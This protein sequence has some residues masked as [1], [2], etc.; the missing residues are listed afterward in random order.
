MLANGYMV[1][2]SSRKQ[3]IYGH[4]DF[5]VEHTSNP[6]SKKISIDVKGNRHLDCIWLELKNVRGNKGW[7]ECCSDVIAFDIVELDSFCFFRRKDLLDFASK[8]K[9]I[10]KDKTEFNKLYTRKGRKDVLVKV[11]YEDIN[12]LEIKK[13]KY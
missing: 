5:F 1:E 10:A 2:E 8:F 6:N 12:K 4:I 9:E 11:K 13:I 3:N 7:L